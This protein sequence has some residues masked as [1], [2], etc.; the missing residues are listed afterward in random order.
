LSVYAGT[1]TARD[2][3]EVPSQLLENWAW[4]YDSLKLF[5]K[6]YQTRQVLPHELFDK[7]LAA[8]N[9][10]SGLHVQQQILYGSY[11]LTLHGSYQPGGEESTTDVIRRLQNQL[12]L[13]PYVEGTHFEAAFGHLTGYAASYYS[14]LWSLVYAE[15]IFEVFAKKGIMDTTLGKKYREAILAKGGSED[16]MQQ[17][18][19]FLERAPRP[20]AFIRS[21]GL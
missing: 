2:F 14:Y 11:D 16:E 1:N 21:L 9:L 7:M 17:L 19:T 10:G 18:E 12:T 5:A 15:D 6:H 13:F 20:D 8:K 4:H 3:V